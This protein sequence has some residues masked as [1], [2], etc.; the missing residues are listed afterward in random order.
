MSMTEPPSTTTGIPAALHSAWPTVEVREAGEG[1]QVILAAADLGE[2]LVSLSTQSF[3][4]SDL[5]AIDRSALSGVTAKTMR[6]IYH[7]R[8]PIGSGQGRAWVQLSADFDP[9]ETALA[10]ITDLYPG[11][12]WLEREVVEMFGIRFTGQQKRSLILHTAS[13]SQHPLRKSYPLH[14]AEGDGETDSTATGLDTTAPLALIPTLR[15]RL[16]VVAGRVVRGMPVPGYAHSGIEKLSE[17]LTYMQGLVTCARLNDQAPH[18]ASL[19]LALAVEAMLGIEV[20]PKG[21]YQRV[22]ISELCRLAGHLSWLSIQ[23]ETAG[24][25][26][27]WRQ[28]MQLRASVLD[29]MDR[30]TGVGMGTGLLAIG[31]QAVDFPADFKECGLALSSSVRVVVARLHGQL[32]GNRLWR[33]LVEGVAELSAGEAVDWGL[34]GPTLRACGTRSDLRKTEPYLAYGDLDFDV[35][36]G[37]NGDALDRCRVRMEEMIQSASL[38]EQALRSMPAGP[39]RSEDPRVFPAD[40][41]AQVRERVEVMIRHMQLWTEGHGLRVPAG[42]EFYQATESPNGELG[43][44]LCADGTDRPYRLHLRSPSLLNFQVAG[45]LI[46]GLPLEQARQALCSLNIVPSEMDR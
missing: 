13:P 45:G 38:I 40:N 10:S 39:W 35:I 19:S 22:V 32:M 5:T 15:M 44:F 37:S 4:L 29:T 23:T 36:V 12:D 16:D 3:T 8:S 2:V 31:G 20:P 1:V 43:V 21:S 42:V 24:E 27:V 41:S 11:A 14:G 7:L 26:R 25:D 30:L 6:I 46:A 28:A 9:D 18:S 34:T 33:D 17:S